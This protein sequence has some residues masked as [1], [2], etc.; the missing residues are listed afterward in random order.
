MNSSER[1]C[2]DCKCWVVTLASGSCPACGRLV[3]KSHSAPTLDL[4]D[5]SSNLSVDNELAVDYPTS[6]GFPACLLG[7]N[8]GQY[9]IQS[10]L[11][12]GGMAWVFLGR[13]NTLH[14]PC[15]IKVLCPELFGRNASSLDSFM[16]E[17][18]AAAS[19]IHPH[20]VAIHNVGDLE[21][22]YFIEMEY[23]PG[24]SLEQL[25][26]DRSSLSLHDATKFLCQACSA[27][28]AAH[29]QGLAHRDFKPANILIRSDGIAKLADFGLAKEL[30]N[31]QVTENVGLAGTP[32]FMAPELFRGAHASAQSDI[33]AVGVSYYLT[34][35]GRYPFIDK[36]IT[37][38]AQAHVDQP[39]PD[40]R[41]F[42]EDLS[43]EVIE[44]LERCLA[45]QPQDRFEDCDALHNEL[46]HLFNGMRNFSNLVT[47]AL[48][49]MNVE[50]TLNEEQAVVAVRLPEGR[51]Q[52]VRV[53]VNFAQSVRSK[54][55]RI[56]SICGP[57][58]DAH[59]QRALEFNASMPHGAIAIQN[60]EDKPHF[61]MLNNYLKATCQE[62]EIRRS[63]QEIARWADNMEQKLTG[64]DDL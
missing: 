63:V 28:A 27:L 53:E 23:V 2:P 55:I 15:A 42:R 45:K 26:F 33:Y 16:E 25:I 12:K 59:L 17:A 20:I 37:G 22:H 14:R 47:T 44:V 40:P 3:S 31:D 5:V 58:E 36:T 43:E 54:L 38:I 48:A 60:I 8:V 52:R 56:S 34:L 4:S 7:K 51:S 39:L 35:T 41:R 50:L 18:R 10:L 19:L 13:H 57:V 11:G 46:Q 62:E 29:R 30:T 6:E 21:S 9:E 64:R 24:C 32:K 1:F 49:G 61:V